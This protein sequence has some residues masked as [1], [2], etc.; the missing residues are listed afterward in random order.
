MAAY[1][2]VDSH[3]LIYFDAALKSLSMLN[4]NV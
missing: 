2:S 3:S 4:V 1:T